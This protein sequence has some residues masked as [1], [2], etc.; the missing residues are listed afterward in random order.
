MWLLSEQ[1]KSRPRYQNE[2][3]GPRRGSA[4]SFLGIGKIFE[5][6]RKQVHSQPQ[7]YVV[8]RVAARATE[9]RSG[10]G[11]SCPR[12]HSYMH[13]PASRRALYFFFVI[14]HLLTH[15]RAH[16]EV[17]T[18]PGQDLKADIRY[19]PLPDLTTAPAAS[20]AFRQSPRSHYI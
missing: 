5:P 7:R 15:Y 3:A 11:K 16:L 2:K 18:K 20:P 6:A 9:P 4:F 14:R 19:T 17:S 10:E 12:Y 8:S 1:R 13:S